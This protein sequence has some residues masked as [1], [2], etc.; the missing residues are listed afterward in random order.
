LRLEIEDLKRDNNSHSKTSID[1]EKKRFDR[2]NLTQAKFKD[3]SL[4]DLIAR[5]EYLEKM[6]G[7]KNS[8]GDEKDKLPVIKRTRGK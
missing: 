3:D 7:S 1:D 4:K 2:G 5:I 6:L 8:I